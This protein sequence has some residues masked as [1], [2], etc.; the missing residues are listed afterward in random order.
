MSVAVTMPSACQSAA[1]R[2]ATRLRVFVDTLF[3]ITY[4]GV[5]VCTC[6]PVGWLMMITRLGVSF[7]LGKKL[8]DTNERSGFGLGLIT[9]K[10]ITHS[11]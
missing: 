6:V 8:H 4:K 3:D 7:G 5:H 1:N 2:M 11:M 10:I 9:Q